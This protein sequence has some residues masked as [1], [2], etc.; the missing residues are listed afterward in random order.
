MNLQNSICPIIDNHTP[1]WLDSIFTDSW[2]SPSTL[3]PELQT[4]FG[5]LEDFSGKFYN[6]ATPELS[7]LP[8]RLIRHNAPKVLLL[9]LVVDFVYTRY[10]KLNKAEI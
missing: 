9:N 8:S 2:W 4:D 6:Q 10:N 3:S 5:I 1:T 7:L